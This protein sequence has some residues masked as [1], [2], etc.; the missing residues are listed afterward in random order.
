VG[1]GAESVTI[2][3]QLRRKIPH[4]RVYFLLSF[5]YPVPLPHKGSEHVILSPEG[6]KD[7][8]L[9]FED[10]RG[11]GPA[12]SWRSKG[13]RTCFFFLKIEGAKDLLLLFGDRVW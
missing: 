12:S 1:R 5:L 6:A 10:R 9:L 4:D 7:L 3:S 2:F 11:E 13:R 8:L